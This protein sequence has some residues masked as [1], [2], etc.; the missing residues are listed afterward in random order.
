MAVI[1]PSAIDNPGHVSLCSPQLPSSE[2][3]QPYDI[4]A[5]SIEG[6]LGLVWGGGN[7]FVNPAA[8]RLLAGAGSL[9]MPMKTRREIRTAEQGHVYAQAPRKDVHPAVLRIN[10]TEY[11]SE[12][13]AAGEWLYTSR[14]TGDRLNLMEW[15]NQG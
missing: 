1:Y 3:G 12:N 2:Q 4:R 13:E 7:W 8:Q 10:G 9:P 14:D 11:F 15:L 5:L 6:I